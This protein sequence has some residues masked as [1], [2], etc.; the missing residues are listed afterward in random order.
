MAA[1]SL[2]PCDRRNFLLFLIIR[3]I[4]AED[5]TLQSG[6]RIEVV[7]CDGNET[8]DIDSYYGQRRIY[9]TSALLR[10]LTNHCLAGRLVFRGPRSHR[11]G[12]DLLLGHGNLAIRVDLLSRVP[13]EEWFDVSG[14]ERSAS[15]VANI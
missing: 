15:H 1:L 12:E 13:F 9:H 10:Y 3:L 14:Y 7:N 4:P 2:I 5:D 8:S 6:N 11:S